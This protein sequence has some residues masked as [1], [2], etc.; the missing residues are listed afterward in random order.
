[1]TINQLLQEMDGFKTD[2]DII[3]IERPSQVC[4]WSGPDGDP[5]VDITIDVPMPDKDGRQD[6][7]AH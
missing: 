7:L 4:A 2:E 1:M 6:I 5:V 3:I